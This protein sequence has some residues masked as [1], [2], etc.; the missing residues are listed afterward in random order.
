MRSLSETR[1]SMRAMMIAAVLV[2][3]SITGLAAGIVTQGVVN[4][5]GQPNGHGPFI[6]GF[7]GSA[8][9]RTPSAST[10]TQPAATATATQPAVTI[11]YP[12]SLHAVIAPPTVAP[13]Q[14]FTV[15]VTTTKASDGSAVAGL[16]CYMRAADGS[17][18][19][20]Q[21]WPAPVV[22][23]AIGQAVWTL[24]VPQAAAG[25]YTIEIIGYG[26]PPIQA[27]WDPTVTITS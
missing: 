21:D 18:P 9:T 6:S 13:G 23:D 10:P 25:Q 27:K 16:K 7:G 19:L 26:T 11:T 5:F 24:T 17:A 1:H 20:Y 2:A 3:F 4:P 14:T 15:T 12:F 8:P 22:T